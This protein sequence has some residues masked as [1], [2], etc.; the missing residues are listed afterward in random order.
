[1]RKKINFIT[2]QKESQ[3]EFN[4]LTRSSATTIIIL[5][6]SLHVASPIKTINKPT[7]TSLVT[8]IFGI[9]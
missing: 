3:E 8:N 5:G 2:S 6:F 4:P 7:I 9:D 1:M